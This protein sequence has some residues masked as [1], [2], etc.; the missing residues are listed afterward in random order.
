MRLAVLSDIHGNVT[1]FEAA[2]DDLQAQG[3]AD[4]T[5]ILGDIAA[6]GP[7]PAE[8]VQRVKAL[9]DA[10]KDDEQKRDTIR[11]ISGNTDRYLV[12]GTRP[13]FPAAKSAEDFDSLRYALKDFSDR[14][15]WCQDQ[16]GFEQYEFLH[17][18]PT[19]CDLD[20]GDYGYVIGYHAI[21][22]DDE[23]QALMPDSSEEA[24][25]DALLDRE[26]RLGIGG[27]NHIQMDRTVGN[28]RA[29][30]VG[31]IG[32][33]FDQNIGKAE[34]GIFTFE[35]GEVQVDL[36]A[37]PYDMDAVIADSEMRGNPATSWLE[38]KLR[39]SS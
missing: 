33:P 9:V 27:H 22:G 8:S 3:G 10:V 23:S 32:C 39:G 6:F 19:E 28:W 30:N 34:Y 2:L 29:V 31:S 35:G 16:L 7:R 14:V 26:G 38:S 15:H 24:A 25:S 1:A 5:W 17:K 4:V 37:I 20:A 12:Y 21:P 18:L 13:K 36:R 11:V